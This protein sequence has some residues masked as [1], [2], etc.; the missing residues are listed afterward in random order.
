MGPGTHVFKRLKNKVEPNGYFGNADIASMYHDILYYNP[1]MSEQQAD[2][3][4]LS[5]ISKLNP[6]YWIMRAGFAAKD[7]VGGIKPTKD[8]H[9]YD[10]AVQL[11]KKNFPDIVKDYNLEF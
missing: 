1:H 3:L 6:F 2:K 9:K 8:Q 7:M 11:V 10:H 4:A 5:K